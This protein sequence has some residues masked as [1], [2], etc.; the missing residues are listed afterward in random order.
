LQPAHRMPLPAKKRPFRAH[1]DEQ[2]YGLLRC[3]T[4]PRGTKPDH[5]LW[6]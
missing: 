5:R 6:W 4:T 3:I 2:S 1:L